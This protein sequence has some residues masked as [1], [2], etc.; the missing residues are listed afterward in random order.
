M[1]ASPGCRTK[2]CALSSHI[3]RLPHAA[4][5]RSRLTRPCPP[6]LQRT[7]ESDDRFNTTASKAGG[8]FGRPKVDKYGHARKKESDEEESEES[9]EESE[10]E[11]QQLQS[12]SDDEEDGVAGQSSLTEQPAWADELE[13]DD[14]EQVEIG[15]SARRLA[16][17]DCDWRK[18]KAVDILVIVSSFI[19]PGGSI[20][21]VTV[22]P[23]GAVSTRSTRRHS[24]APLEACRDRAP[25]GS[26]WQSSAWLR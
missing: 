10:E 18:M 26:C 25:D 15:D 9:G 4:T 8:R 5:A 24:C 1:S 13:E 21:N 17:L 14:T 2:R 22:Y 23:S 7:V 16:V 6:R 11:Q 20:K 19:P 12:G 3:N